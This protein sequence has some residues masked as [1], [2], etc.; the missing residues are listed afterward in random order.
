MENIALPGLMM[1]Y[2]LTMDRIL[3][4]ANRMYPQKRIST[5]L[6]DGSFHHYTYS[7]LYKRAKRL[8]NVL[9]RVGVKAGDRVGTFSWNNYQHLELY[10]GT[11][12]QSI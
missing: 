12:L 6:A 2:P 8:G 5:K 7:D 3:E 9:D 1:D 4:H 11:L 10:F